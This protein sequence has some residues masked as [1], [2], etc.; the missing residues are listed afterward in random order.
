MTWDRPR[1]CYIV[2]RSRQGW[3][4]NVNSDFLSAHDSVESARAEARM[5][6]DTAHQEGLLAEFIDLS[7]PGLDGRAG[8]SPPPDAP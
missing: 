5:L 7:D 2:T 8:P 4:V 6:T 1:V 3:A